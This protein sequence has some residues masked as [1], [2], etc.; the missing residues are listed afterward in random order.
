MLSSVSSSAFNTI[1]RRFLATVRGG[2]IAS[3]AAKTVT[4]A[5]ED[6]SQA[7]VPRP[8]GIDNQ[9]FLPGSH[10]VCVDDKLGMVTNPEGAV[11]KF[12]CIHPELN[13]DDLCPD[14]PRR[15]FEAKKSD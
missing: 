8:V 14:C 1:S 10:A 9:W 6:G 4:V 13:G 7:T 12:E 2:Q 3:V 15:K 11:L 5:L